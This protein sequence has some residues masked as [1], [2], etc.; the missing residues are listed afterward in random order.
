M[1][2]PDYAR[3]ITRLATFSRLIRFDRRGTGM[4][5]R[6]VRCSALEERV[7]DIR[8]VMDAAG[9]ERAALLGVSE[10]GSMCAMFAATHPERTSALVLYGAFARSQWAPDYPWGVREEQ[11][12]AEIAAME[13]TL[14]GPFELGDGAPSVANDEAARSWFGAYLRY[15]A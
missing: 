11:R 15:S 12:E 9:S 1:L 2:D 8:A 13:E 7:D 14:G 6:D 4:S 3:L 10:G 5:D